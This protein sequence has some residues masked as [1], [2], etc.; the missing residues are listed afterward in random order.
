M[1]IFGVSFV[2]TGFVIFIMAYEVPYVNK[3]V[4]L[5]DDDMGK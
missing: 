2:S 1:I 3:H 5:I 4:V